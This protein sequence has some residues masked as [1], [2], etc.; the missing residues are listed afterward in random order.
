MKRHESLIT[1]SH[2]HHEGLIIAQLLRKDVPDYEG[3]PTSVQGKVEHLQ[4]YYQNDLSVHFF[5]EEDVLF[6]AV[7][8]LSDEIAQLVQ[9][10][11][12]QHQQIKSAIALV[13]RQEASAD[14]LHELGL[15]LRDH[16]R[17]EERQLFPQIQEMATEELLNELHAK[18][19][20]EDHD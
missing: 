12:S 11:I 2:D 3:M 1:L 8:G 7:T 9:E 19:K 17:K 16:I 15:L 13:F 5:K 14:S 4:K 10:L 6:P 18:L 20:E